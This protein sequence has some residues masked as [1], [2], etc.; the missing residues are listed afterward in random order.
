MYD[1]GKLYRYYLLVC[2]NKINSVYPEEFFFAELYLGVK[3]YPLHPRL[4]IY[5]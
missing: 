1:D 5:I 2:R 4:E 3:S